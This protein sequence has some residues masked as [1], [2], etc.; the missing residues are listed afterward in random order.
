MRSRL[1]LILTA[2]IAFLLS[3][4]VL[5]V[6]DE[7]VVLDF[8]DLPGIYN[9]I[10][11]GYGGIADW[12]DYVTCDL[13]DPNYPPHS[14]VVWGYCFGNGSPIV[15]GTE[16]I[17]DG[18]WIAGPDGPPSDVVWFELYLMGELVHTSEGL[19]PT[20][21]HAWLASGW[22]TPVDEVRIWHTFTNVWVFDDFTYTIPAVDAENNSW[23]SVKRL[24]R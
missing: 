8:E 4:P 16:Y 9:P 21:T 5:V 19:H 24:Y 3:S 6:A 14:G 2:T 13:E 18:A 12:T 7:T 22:D 17:F 10:P 11:P 15:F 23:G 1:M 20:P